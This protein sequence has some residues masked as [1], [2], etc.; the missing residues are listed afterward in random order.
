MLKGFSIGS[1]LTLP[2]PASSQNSL[3]FAS[4]NPQVPKAAPS[5]ASE[6]V[7]S[8]KTRFWIRLGEF[9]QG[10][11]IA[12]S[13]IGHADNTC[14]SGTIIELG[15]H[16]RNGGK[17]FLEEQILEPRVGKPLQT[18]PHVVTIGRLRDPS[19]IADVDPLPPN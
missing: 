4:G 14:H 18:A 12:R 17:P 3:I 6:V 13:D 2:N 19:S 10:A 16:I 11:S 15:L 7:I 9:D 8:Y 1:R 5:C